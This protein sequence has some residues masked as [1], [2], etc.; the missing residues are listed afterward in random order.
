MDKR[1]EKLVKD[2][3]IYILKRGGHKVK[4]GNNGNMIEWFSG[5]WFADK[6]ELLLEQCSHCAN[7]LAD[8]AFREYPDGII[9]GNIRLDKTF[10]DDYKQTYYNFGI[11]FGDMK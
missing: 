8:Y 11:E 6:E 3:V 4:C 7:R 10:H 2:M 1:L 5:F 9:V